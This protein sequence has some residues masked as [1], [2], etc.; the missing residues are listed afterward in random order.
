MDKEI[1]TS[2]VLTLDFGKLA[3]VPGGCVPVAVQDAD[4]REVILVAYTNEAAM[5]QAFARRRLIL[6]SSSRNALWEK[7]GTSG[8]TFTL[9]EA[10]VNCEQN[11]LVYI[12]RADGGGMCHTCDGEGRHR[13]TCFYRKINFDT[14]NLTAESA[15]NAEGNKNEKN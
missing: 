10:Y 15:E 7:G 1:E 8:D 3:S 4:S 5:R 11:S 9:V 13:K 2:G 12:V 14:L 6:W